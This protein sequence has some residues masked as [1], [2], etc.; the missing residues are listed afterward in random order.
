[1][2][3]IFSSEKG[4]EVKTNCAITK[5][6]Y[7]YKFELTYTNYKPTRAWMIP[8][9][10]IE[11]YDYYRNIIV[12]PE[13][14]HLIEIL[15]IYSDCNCFGLESSTSCLDKKIPDF[16]LFP[17]LKRIIYIPNEIYIPWQTH[18]TISTYENGVLRPPEP[19]IKVKYD[20]GCLLIPDGVTD[21]F[22]NDTA[23][24]RADFIFPKSLRSACF[25]KETMNHPDFEFPE[26]LETLFLLHPT[27]KRLPNLKTLD[28]C[29]DYYSEPEFSFDDLPITLEILKID[30]L[31]NFTD[32]YL[33]PNPP[34]S[35]RIV[36]MKNQNI[37]SDDIDFLSSRIMP[38]TPSVEKITFN[39]IIVFQK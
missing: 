8:V 23:T 4:R 18:T 7:D 29:F 11:S 9:K 17:N 21:L 27:K 33:I 38:I 13:D 31:H 36:E 32:S 1:M 24:T 28:I 20:D 25:S 5:Y 16:T 10:S 14:Y 37:K 2:G 34:P 19:M 6:N 26:T 35:L 39:G 22:L 12:K 15:V 3:S 30:L